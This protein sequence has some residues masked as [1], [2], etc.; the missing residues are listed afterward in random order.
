MGRT[1]KYE[2]SLL[3]HA[4]VKYIFSGN[5][6]V[7]GESRVETPVFTRITTRKDYTVLSRQIGQGVLPKETNPGIKTCT[8]DYNMPSFPD[9]FGFL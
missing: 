9:L 2:V 7:Q 5:P 1:G 8:M 3:V 4:R 6:N